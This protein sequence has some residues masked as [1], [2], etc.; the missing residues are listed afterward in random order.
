MISDDFICSFLKQAGVLN[1][2]TLV[3]K[4]IKENNLSI[5]SIFSEENILFTILNSYFLYEKIVPYNIVKYIENHI[6]LL[7]TDSLLVDYEVELNLIPLLLMLNS[8]KINDYINSYVNQDIKHRI[9]DDKIPFS[10]AKRIMENDDNLNTLNLLNEKGIKIKQIND[11][12]FLKYAKNEKTVLWLLENEWVDFL[13]QDKD[14]KTA[15]Y[16]ISLLKNSSS[17]KIYKNLNKKFITENK[18]EEYNSLLI[19]TFAYS[20]KIS[21]F[22]TFSKDKK[23]SEMNYNNQNILSHYIHSKIIQN[24][25]IDSHN[26][27]R[28]DTS[29]YNYILKR[30]ENSNEED[31]FDCKNKWSA[32]YLFFKHSYIQDFEE[33]IFTSIKNE[34]DFHIL[35]NNMD[36]II[37][38]IL[39]DEKQSSSVKLSYILSFFNIDIVGLCMG[40]IYRSQ[41][42]DKLEKRFNYNSMHKDIKM[43]SDFNMIFEIFIKVLKKY[44]EIMKDEN[45]SKKNMCYG[46]RFKML[47]K[48]PDD[49]KDYIENMP[50]LRE[51]LYYLYYNL[52]VN[53]TTRYREKSSELFNLIKI[54][55]HVNKKE[56][57]FLKEKISDDYPSINAVFENALIKMSLNISSENTKKKKRM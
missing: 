37:S 40:F 57:V 14:Y 38:S 39:N 52:V 42:P 17:E 8:K 43:T 13:Y 56:V 16:Y 11:F 45:V 49:Y 12:H 20:R 5:N 19:Y 55:D 10:I 21:L 29:K 33:K 44:Y 41:N 51:G 50:T 54:P 26:I 4:F 22:K 36:N 3:L 1:D 47:L 6:E 23:L 25:N 7:L 28:F 2:D 15:Y 31:Y 46:S 30:L 48:I 34:N 27:F 35:I 53:T 32:H 18:E 24:K 9:I